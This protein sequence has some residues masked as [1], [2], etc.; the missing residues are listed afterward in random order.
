MMIEPQK[1]DYISSD[2]DPPAIIAKFHDQDKTIEF[3]V[4]KVSVSQT[5]YFL[6]SQIIFL[7]RLLKQRS[8]L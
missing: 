1:L 3:P 2:Y 6:K 4:Q 8:T 5:V 7:L